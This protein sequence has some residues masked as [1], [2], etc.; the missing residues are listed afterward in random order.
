MDNI[1]DILAGMGNTPDEIAAFLGGQG[2][3]GRLGHF[4]QCPVACYLQR[5]GLDY[6]VMSKLAWPLSNHK[7][8]IALPF[9]VENFIYRFDKG[10]YPEL[11]I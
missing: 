5:V 6:G 4:R 10:Q 3:R 11:V 9:A 2:I 8:G 7:P 1:Q